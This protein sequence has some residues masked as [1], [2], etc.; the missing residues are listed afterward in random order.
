[1][2]SKP[3]P[4]PLRAKTVDRFWEYVVRKPRGCWGWGSAMCPKGYGY[5]C[6]DY[7]NFKA[8]RLS[9]FIHYNVDPGDLMV[10]HRCD[11]P[12]CT[13]PRHLFLGTHSQNML[14]SVRKGRHRSNQ[15][16]GASLPQF[17]GERN[18]NAKLSSKD[19]TSIL[20]ASVN[21]VTGVDLA[22]KYG[23]TPTAIWY[24]LH[25]KTHKALTAKGAK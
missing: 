3:I 6:I 1:M 21:G 17:S 13:N 14:D 8:H 19:V 11:N 7:T 20:A 18:A 5:M 15:V 16:R 2:R 24:V 23:V 12:S 10:C 25:G 22:R 9:Y 4:A